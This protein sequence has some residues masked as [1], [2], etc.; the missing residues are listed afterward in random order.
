MSGKQTASF[1]KGKRILITGHTGFKGAWLSRILINLGAKVSGCSL[2]PNT[3]PNL[4]SIFTLEREMDS[5]ILDIRDQKELASVFSKD[6]PELVFH[7]AA[8]PLVRDS[9]DDPLY[10]FST[11][12]I[13]TAN[14]LECV[15]QSSDAKAAVIV[16]TDKVY[17]NNGSGRAYK[18]SDPLGG[19]DPYSASKSCAEFVVR[20]YSSSFFSKGDKCVATARAGNV[21]GGGDWSK[22]RLIPDVVRAFI[23]GKKDLALRNPGSIRPWQHVFDPLFGYLLLGKKLY[24]GKCAGEWNFAPERESAI[25]V[26]ELVKRSIRLLGKGK[27]DIV[28]DNNKYEMATLRLDASKSKKLL[29]WEPVLGI[30]ESL[31]WTI[32]WYRAYYSGEDVKKLSDNQISSF[33]ER[34]DYW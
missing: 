28:P 23:D 31:D 11:N 4:H 10:T 24:E 13:G 16:T 19:H 8:Q 6:K 1:F 18:E 26:E 12:V 7:L 30:E 15:R 29:G 32:G 3:T 34:A 25:T 9:Y 17:D 5:H 2:Q 14:V 33:M 27:Y 21:M 22:D 20:S